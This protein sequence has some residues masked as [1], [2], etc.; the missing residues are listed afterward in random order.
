MTGPLTFWLLILAGALA[1][2]AGFREVSASGQ[3]WSR[4]LL[5]VALGVILIIRA[6]H[7]RRKV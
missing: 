5:F 1:I 6:R 4:G 7:Y 2:V 3:V